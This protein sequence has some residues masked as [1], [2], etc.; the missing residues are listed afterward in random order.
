M[1]ISKFSVEGLFGTSN[2][3]LE[4]V[5][6]RLILVG[7]NGSGKST[8]V[9]ILYYLLTRQWNLL[10]DFPFEFLK[11]EID[12][13]AYP[14][15]REDIVRLVSQKENARADSLRVSSAKWNTLFNNVKLT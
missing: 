2:Y 10:T 3:I 14:I 7:E 15:A 1:N 8:I 12:D 9:T 6:N 4:L 13:V 5:N 11:L